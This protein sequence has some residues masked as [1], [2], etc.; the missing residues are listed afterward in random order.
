MRRQS[1]GVKGNEFSRVFRFRSKADRRG[2]T[3]LS[4]KWRKSQDSVKVSRLV[5]E[6]ADLLPIVGIKYRPG[7][8]KHSTRGYNRLQMTLLML[9]A[10]CIYITARVHSRRY[11]LYFLHRVRSRARKIRRS[12]S[13]TR[14]LRAPTVRHALCLSFHNT[15]IHSIS[16]IPGE[17]TRWKKDFERIWERETNHRA[18][19]QHRVLN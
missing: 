4:E 17:K 13:P 6:L 3:R 5:Y 14:E 11:N 9:A 10:R 1:E 2:A 16:P 8:V 18:G 19:K 7:I 15:V 12:V